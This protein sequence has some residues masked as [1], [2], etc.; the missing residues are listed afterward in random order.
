MLPTP[1]D[2]QIAR[3]PFEATRTQ[4]YAEE[5]KT[6]SEII[7]LQGLRNDSSYGV[8]ALVGGEIVP[9]NMLAHVR[10]KA[11]AQVI[12]RVVPRGGQ[13]GKA[14]LQ[15]VIAIVAI[16]AVAFSPA[17]GA[18]A[19]MIGGPGGLTGAGLGAAA[20]MAGGL[21]GVASGIQSLVAPPPSVPFGGDIATSQDSAALTGTRNGARLYGPVRTVL[22]EYRVYP[23]LLAKPFS[24][25]VG[26]DSV[27]RMLLCFGY[28]PL[29]I[30]DIKIG[31]TP[32]GDLI[33]S[34][35]YAVLEGWDD[36][37]DLTIFRDDVEEDATLQREFTLEDQRATTTVTH[38]FAT[39]PGPEEISIDLQFPGGLIS[40]GTSGAPHAV[41]VRFTIQER[42]EGDVGW[43]D[44]SRPTMGLGTDTGVTE[45][46]AGLFEF[47]L[48]ERGA[49]TRG[50]RWDVP[51]GSTENAVHQIKIS[52]TLT[53]T[54]VSDDDQ[55]VSD[56]RMLV[57][58]TIKPHVSSSIANLAKIELRINASETGLS[59][60]IDNLSAVCTSIVPKWDS[61]SESWGP[62][63]ANAAALGVSMHKTRNAAW[64]YA[65][66]LRGPA[67]SI[68]VPDNR[69]D[70]PS[71]SAWAGNLDG[72][73]S[74]AISGTDFVARNL[75]AVVDY[76]T[77]VRKVLSDIAG[78]G[79]A[80]LNIIDGK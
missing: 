67:N 79:R 46:S 2:V 73:G 71:I 21:M 32:I 50:L 60:M 17:G 49:V 58:R 61:T 52:R 68:P 6:L 11:G 8:I 14:I 37:P 16:A 34:S 76:S 18:L 53:T 31:E 30:T 36:D 39:K 65:H 64:L 26:K 66:T 23:D 57:I 63:H 74:Y 3:N 22:G 28:G 15:I 62:T 70:G 10:P 80:S 77:T 13:K 24:E 45:I 19:A 55:I 40:F 47:N 54:P 25:R 42:E 59:G 69:I 43:T 56:A 27:L 75:D 12:L 4:G 29:D 35:D 72:T 78:A 48:A 33:P 41:K 5:G 51:V 7:A 1:L 44:I 20:A 38:E 9:E